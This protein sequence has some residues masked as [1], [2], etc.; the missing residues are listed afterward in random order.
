MVLL[1]Y[2]AVSWWSKKQGGLSLSTVESEFVEAS[3][4]G[5]ELLGIRETLTEIGVIP[6]LP[7]TMHIDNQAAIVQIAGEA[8]ST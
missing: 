3:E 4:A 7:L 2:M 8:T 5:R 1:N 6:T